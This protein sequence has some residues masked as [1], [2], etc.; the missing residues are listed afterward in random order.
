MDSIV[1]EA[2]RFMESRNP[3]HYDSENPGNAE[4]MG[5]GCFTMAKQFN[6]QGISGKIVTIATTGYRYRCVSCVCACVCVLTPWCPRHPSLQHAHGVQVPPQH[7]DPGVHGQPEGGPRAQR[8][9]GSPEHLLPTG[10][11]RLGR[12]KGPQRHHD[13]TPQKRVSSRV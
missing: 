2:E 6:A 4:L 7:S 3:D 9:V 1:G 13:G 11:R 12:R 8:R 5:H 10:H